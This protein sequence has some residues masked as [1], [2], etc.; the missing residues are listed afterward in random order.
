L[1]FS[2]EP[3][4]HILKYRADGTPPALR[5]TVHGP[6]GPISLKTVHWTVFLALDVPVPFVLP[7][8]YPQTSRQIKICPFPKKTG[9]IARAGIRLQVCIDQPMVMP[10]MGRS[11]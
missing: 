11:K 4:L 8:A 3:P 10:S 7:F 1:F 5:G 9:A 2:L 6:A